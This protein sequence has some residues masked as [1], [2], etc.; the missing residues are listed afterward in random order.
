MLKKSLSF[1]LNV[2]IHKFSKRWLTVGV[3]SAGADGGTPSERKRLRRGKC[4]KNAQ[5]PQRRVHAVLG[6]GSRLQA[7]LF[8]LRFKKAFA[9][10]GRSSS[11]DDIILVTETIVKR[12]IAPQLLLL[13]GKT[14][15]CYARALDAPEHRIVIHIVHRAARGV[16]CQL[17]PDSMPC[18]RYLCLSSRRPTA[19]VTR[20][21][22]GRE[23]AILSES[24]PSHAEC[25]K[26]RRL[27]PVGCTLCWAAFQPTTCLVLLFMKLCIGIVS[28]R[29]STSP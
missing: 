28:T 10:H 6:G 16:R 19:G 17:E 8:N 26:T 14:M 9:A 5:S 20:W 1:W 3:T 22:V 13:A 18:K 7:R 21:W 24:T 11:W 29:A 25:S 27:L 23:N 15:T 2:I 12:L 4:L